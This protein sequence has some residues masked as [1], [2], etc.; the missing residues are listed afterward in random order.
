MLILNTTYSRFQKRLLAVAQTKPLKKKLGSKMR[1]Q[2]EGN[3]QPRHTNSFPLRE[4][5]G[6]W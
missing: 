5:R 1:G 4:D 2:D 6:G 3:K